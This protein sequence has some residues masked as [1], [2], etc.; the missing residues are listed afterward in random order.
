LSASGTELKLAGVAVRVSL[1]S[2][3]GVL[4]G[5]TSVTT[6]DNGRA[7]FRDLAL[8][9]LPGDYVL[10]FEADGFLPVDSRTIDLR[11]R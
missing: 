2:G 6:D 3:P 11:L 5:T 9:G 8:V 7:K 1:A 4:V 10:R